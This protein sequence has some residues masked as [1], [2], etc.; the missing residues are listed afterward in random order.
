MTTGCSW[1]SVDINV[2]G[3]NFLDITYF[4]VVYNT[5]QNQKL[6]ASLASNFLDCDEKKLKSSDAKRIKILKAYNEY[7][8]F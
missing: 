7:Q 4:Q 2:T 5:I 3:Y 1:N 8:L 6:Y